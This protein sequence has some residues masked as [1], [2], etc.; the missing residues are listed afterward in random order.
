MRFT[1]LTATAVFALTAAEQIS[2]R[3]SGKR[4]IGLNLDP[5]TG[6]NID[7]CRLQL[8]GEIGKAGWCAGP[9][10]QGL[11]LLRIVLCHLSTCR[12]AG[13]QGQGR[14]AQQQRSSYSISISHGVHVLLL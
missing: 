11:H 12:K 4:V 14:T 3:G 6:R 5:L 2:K 13:G 8:L 9:G 10:G 1:G 7:H